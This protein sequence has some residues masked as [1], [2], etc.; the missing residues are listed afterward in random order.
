MIHELLAEGA[1]NAKTGREICNL[2]EISLRELTAAVEQERRAGIPI[3]ASM[4]GKRAGYFL[5]ANREEMQR[6]CRS[7][8]HRAGELHKTHRACLQTMGGLP[9]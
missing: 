1:E 8:L 6:Y 2:L 7:L 9:Q 5:A 3:C 4:S